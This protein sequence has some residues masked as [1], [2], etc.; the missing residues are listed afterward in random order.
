[1]KRLWTPWRMKLIMS[2]KPE[3]CLFCEKAPMAN[4]K[5]NLILFRGSTCF[6]MLNAYPYNNGHVMVAPYAHA[7]NLDQLD[8]PAMTEM[9]LL[10]KRSVTALQRAMNPEGY[11]MGINVGKV[12]GAGVEHH[13]H[14]HVVPRWLGDTNFMSTLAEMRVIP[15]ALDETYDK[16]IAAGIADPELA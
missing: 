5:E 13:I 14:F 7:R 8:T 1:M 16:L 4:D 2:P 15:E 9:M 11:N 10:A 3:G 6:I 12:A